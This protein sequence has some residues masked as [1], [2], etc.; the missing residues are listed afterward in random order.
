VSVGTVRGLP[1]TNGDFLDFKFLLDFNE[2]A[3][4]AEIAT[5]LLALVHYVHTRDPAD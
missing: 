2:K 3:R 5:I 1:V 4:A